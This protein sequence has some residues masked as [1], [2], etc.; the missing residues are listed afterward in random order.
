MHQIN[1]HK[2]GLVVGGFA[3]I[4]HLL[5]SLFVALGW[6]GPL[7]GFI[8]GLHFMSHPYMILPFNLLTAVGLI[9]V[10]S[11][12]GY[13]AGSIMGMVWNRVCSSK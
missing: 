8:L 13:V 10:A 12:V 11:C 4:V 9:V 7:L 1:T 2:L 5:W 6:A 3:G